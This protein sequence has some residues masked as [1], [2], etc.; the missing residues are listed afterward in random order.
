[1][2]G[3]KDLGGGPSSLPDDI[4][5]KAGL[6]HGDATAHSLHRA[7][8]H[9]EHTADKVAHDAAD[10]GSDL[11]DRAAD[12]YDDTRAWVSDR[13]DE[14]SRRASRFAQT[15]QRQLRHSRNAAEDFVADNP[16]LVGVVGLAAGLLLGAL[17]PRTRQENE[18]LGPWANEV[19]DQGYRYAR[20]ATRQ[21]RAFVERALDPD[22]LDAAVQQASAPSDGTSS[23]KA[24]QH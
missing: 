3:N 14:H 17:L 24:A 13:Y 9:A 22:A 21:G 10:T 23:P 1:M 2:S 6:P 16:L 18:A 4:A 20:D 15:G 11:R 5:A 8:D 19:R 7:G 12:A